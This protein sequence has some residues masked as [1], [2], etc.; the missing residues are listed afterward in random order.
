MNPDRKCVSWFHYIEAYNADVI[1]PG[2]ALAILK[3]T[4]EHLFLS[5]L[6]KMRVRLMTQV[7]YFK[8]F[9]NNKKKFNTT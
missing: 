9:N 6:M 7:K 4:K 3:V 5:N 8:I 2:N 1:H